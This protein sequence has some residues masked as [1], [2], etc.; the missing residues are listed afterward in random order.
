MFGGPWWWR[1]PLA[2]EG[3]GRLP[4]VAGMPHPESHE[5]SNP[6]GN[7][8]FGELLG[9][10]LTRRTVLAGG[11]GAALAGFLT[12]GRTFAAP[13]S[14]SAFGSPAGPAARGVAARTE[15]LLGFAAVPAGTDDTIVVPEGYTAQVL[16]PW[17]TPLRA[18]GP[19]WK[20]DASNTAA[21]QEHQIGQHHDGMFF[22][23]IDGS[24]TH[25]L[26]VLNHEYIDTVL[27][28]P[29][30]DD[31]ITPE[32]VA[33]ALAAHGMSVVE[34]ELVDDEWQ[35]VD[36]DLNR[37]IT[38]TT[39]VAFSGPVGLDHPALQSNNE[40]MGTINNCGS[41]PSLWNTYLTCEENFHGYFGTVIAEDADAPWKPSETQA[42]LGI[43]AGSPYRWYEVE[44]R[45]DI[46]VNPNEANR[47]GWIVEIDPFDPHSTPIKRTALGRFKH[48][49]ANAVEANGRVVVYMGDDEN[50]EYIYKFVSTNRWADELAAGNSP[51]DDGTLYVAQFNDDGTGAWKP[52]VFGVGPLSKS[53]GFAD[54]A[55]VLIRTREA[56]DRLGA[57]PLDRPEWITTSPLTGETFCCL[58]NGSN[59]TN[60]ANPRLPNP[61]GHILRLS[62]ADKTG[63][64]FEWDVFLLAGDPAYDDGV[65]LDDS[66]IFGSPDGIWADP[67]GLLWIQTDISNSSQNLAEKGYDNIGNNQMLAA[68]PVTGDIRRFLVGPRGAEVTGVHATPDGTSLFVNIQHPGESTPAFAEATPERPTAVSSW[69]DGDPNGRP[70]S[71]TVIVRRTDGGIVGL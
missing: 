18:D 13:G 28:Y 32:K 64:N 43:G 61:Y 69:P 71:A 36:S 47:F 53:G 19:A 12:S 68:D 17:G 9:S 58:T 38:A 31:E 24:S 6:S 59:G 21:D 2:T 63:D 22:Y 7:T 5:S 66:N 27:H 41:G 8:P 10:N 23:A 70:R 1:H 50:G 34:I 40:P 42:R 35:V 39:P 3:S 37:R 56:A 65:E 16:I 11:V 30:G 44:P 54:Q 45:W 14:A 60:P 20:S 15:S 25:G 4:T 67:N 33:K 26:L 62:E 48:E 55:D 29:D 51:L 52:L 57:T 49:A 46:A